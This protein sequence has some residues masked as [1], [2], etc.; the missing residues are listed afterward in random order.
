MSGKLR[1]RVELFGAALLFGLMAALARRGSR[2]AGAFSG[3]QMLFIR[4]AVGIVM[5]LVLFRVQPGTYRPRNVR[6]LVTR[7]L[8]GGVAALLF[9]AALAEIPA[10]EASL[11]NN[12]YPVIAVA[13]A[14]FTLGERPTLHLAAALGMTTLGMVLVVGDGALPRTL[15]CGE[16]LGILSAVLG[17]GAV[18]SIRALRATD[19]APTIFFAFSLG[20]AAASLPLSIHAWPS[21]PSLWWIAILVGVSS[22]VAQL[23]MTDAYGAL[24]VPEAAVWQQL[25]P[26]AAF[27]WAMV[28]LDE[29]LSASRAAGVA[30]G[31]AGVAYGAARSGEP[32]KAPSSPPR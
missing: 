14:T 32:R 3:A 31:V 22:F 4:M 20:G 17:A 18:T 6:L 30:L 11:L 15:G 23:L 2:D 26:L 25:T 27:L 1:A 10:G 19:N 13:A 16:V 28:L 7:G 21:S 29:R 12:T 8:L 24:T 9:F 5:S